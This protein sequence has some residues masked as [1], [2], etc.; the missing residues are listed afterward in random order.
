MTD[1]LGTGTS[2]VLDPENL[3][4]QLVVWQNYKPL[5]DAELNFIGQL[6]TESNRNMIRAMMPSGFIGSPHK[7]YLDYYFHIS[8][9]NYFMLGRQ[10]ESD[11]ATSTDESA[12]VVN[13]LWANV[14]GWVIPITGTFVNE[15][16]VL[17][18][19]DYRNKICLPFAPTSGFR[20]HFV[21][22]E[23]WKQLI[24]VN[25]ST[26]GKPS[27]TTIYKYGN[28]EYGGT[29]VTD[30]LLRTDI[31]AETTKRVQLQYRIR[32][33]NSVDLV[34]YPTGFEDTTNVYARACLTASGAASLAASIDTT[35]SPVAG[36]VGLWRAGNGT[37]TNGLGTTDG[38]TYAIPICAIGRRNRGGWSVS[39]TNGG[40]SRTSPP[41][42]YVDGNQVAGSP[43]TPVELGVVPTSDRPDGLYADYIVLGDIFDM[44]NHV[45]P[46]G[47][48][49][50]SIL[51]ENIQAITNNTLMTSPKYI[52]VGGV[53]Y[54]PKYLVTDELN[55]TG[56]DNPSTILIGE[57]DSVRRIYSDVPIYQAKNLNVT[58]A[59]SKEITSPSYAIDP[60]K[61]MPGD[62]ISIPHPSS[63]NGAD[64]PSQFLTSEIDVTYEG[65]SIPIVAGFVTSATANT[66]VS[67]SAFTTFSADAD[68]WTGYAVIITGGT[69]QGQI[70]TIT[71]IDSVNQIS[72]D[73]SWSVTPD[74]TSSF[75]I[76]APVIVATAT[77][78]TTEMLVTISSINNI[79]SSSSTIIRTANLQRSIW[80]DYTMLYPAGQGLSLHPDT[81]FRINYT[82]PTSTVLRRPTVVAGRNV[83]DVR[84]IAKSR[85]FINPAFINN[86]TSDNTIESESY[87]DEGSKTVLIQ[88]YQR[89]TVSVKPREM[90]T[91]NPTGYHGRFDT[92]YT[93]EVPR[94]YLP[95]LGSSAIPILSAVSGVFATGLNVWVI[96]ES[97]ASVATVINSFGRSSFSDDTYF[98]TYVLAREDA[99]SYE[100]LDSGVPN[101]IGCR[102][103]P[104]VGGIELPQYVGPSRI[105]GIYEAGDFDINGLSATNLL[106]P[107]VE[108]TDI[109][110]NIWIGRTTG[111]TDVTY[112]ILPGAISGYISTTEYVIVANLFGYR[113]GFIIENG[114]VA[115]HEQIA[116]ID[117][118]VTLGI[119][120]TQPLPTSAI[121]QISYDRIPYQGS[122]YDRYEPFANTSPEP[123][124]NRGLVS[125]TD[126]TNLSS[127]LTSYNLGT[128]FHYEILAATEFTTSLGTARF[129]GYATNRF[130]DKRAVSGIPDT[131]PKHEILHM[132]DVDPSQAGLISR[133]PLGARYRDADFAGEDIKCGSGRG[134]FLYI[135]GRNTNTNGE[136]T[137]ITKPEVPLDSGAVITLTQGNNTYST[138]T[139]YRVTRGGSGFHQTDGGSLSA[140]SRETE[141]GFRSLYCVAMLVKTFEESGP[142]NFDLPVNPT[143]NPAIL[144]GRAGE[145]QLVIMSTTVD[146]VFGDQTIYIPQK[147]VAHTNPSGIGE[148][149]T[150]VDRYRCIGRP[151][152]HQT[153]LLPWIESNNILSAQ[154]YDRVGHPYLFNVWPDTVALNDAMTITG[155]NLSAVKVSGSG[156][157]L[158]IYTRPRVSGPSSTWTSQMINIVDYTSTSITFK[159]TPTL[160]SYDVMARAGDGKISILEKAYTIGSSVSGSQSV[161]LV[162]NFM[163]YDV[164]SFPRSVTASTG[165]STNHSRAFRVSD[166]DAYVG[167]RCGYFTGVGRGSSDIVRMD[168]PSTVG[169]YGTDTLV[170][171]YAFQLRDA[172]LDVGNTFTITYQSLLSGTYYDVLSIAFTIA[173]SFFSFTVHNELTGSGDATA[174]S[175]TPL[176]TDW[177]IVSLSVSS[178]GVTSLVFDDTTLVNG[179]TYSGVVLSNN[180]TPGRFLLQNDIVAAVTTAKCLVD[181]IYILKS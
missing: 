64:Y 25:P 148:G 47:H 151:L 67:T 6:N 174:L 110:P 37:P 59:A 52:T 50:D 26:T 154:D 54:G 180:H 91:Y 99:I 43:M 135:G 176:D 138:L 129:S 163:G 60:D 132:S 7:A 27:A 93:V 63:L 114:I 121:I 78:D 122:I 22:L 33:V 72:I 143:T 145:I 42:G 116:N 136:I 159:A 147:I 126:L 24:S 44:R 123:F 70:C 11:G 102:V 9:S 10:I 127:T 49:Y 134:P 173:S 39:T 150:S 162:E 105:I 104:D 181:R 14:N 109:A 172:T 168:I 107:S 34:S 88:P 58:A 106:V 152:E 94:A 87:A 170:F 117:D 66:L 30:D 69:G 68:Q 12:G 158:E 61:W 125:P 156:D 51:S 177:H 140:G 175:T 141:I 62:I 74:I 113:E 155:I 40:I 80:I 144:K 48:D 29:N 53:Q 90:S 95:P 15:D 128:P 18:D 161:S 86:T 17:D 84:H 19:D 13:V 73:G 112:T 130:Y 75:V 77:A 166:V 97:S 164:G 28:V 56:T 100:A 85:D 89:V 157:G 2:T 81:V 178:V 131:Y 41:S 167:D 118:D 119:L 35:F 160:G 32:V 96:S 31:G 65:G 165:W 111:H 3:S 169:T 179:T 83:L 133:L 82:N 45:Q 16:V 57:P 101:K 71:N 153:K 5:T 23:V 139:Q 55:A 36:D 1:N 146:T 115:C 103:N 4:Y 120:I 92:R 98:G 171:R 21:F 79:T 142:T 108:G 46:G 20:T 124:N 38:Y 8:F 149:W 76:Q 137:S